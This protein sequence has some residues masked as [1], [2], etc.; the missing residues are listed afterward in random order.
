MHDIYVTLA[1]HTII[2][3]HMVEANAPACP[4]N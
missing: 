1:M 4:M 2:F 3:T